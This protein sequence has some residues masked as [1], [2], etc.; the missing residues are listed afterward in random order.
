MGGNS[1]PR[2]TARY[3]WCFHHKRGPYN[4]LSHFSWV[5]KRDTSRHVVRYV[6]S[7]WH[8]TYQVRVQLA[9]RTILYWPV[10][11]HSVETWL[12]QE[13][14]RISFACLFQHLEPFQRILP[15]TKHGYTSNHLWTVST[16]TIIGDSVQ[17]RFPL[18]EFHVEPNLAVPF[19]PVSYIWVDSLSWWHDFIN[20]SHLTRAYSDKI[21]ETYMI[22]YI[23]NHR[24]SKFERDKRDF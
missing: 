1:L 19:G 17:N 21:L 20:V 3:L 22:I 11:D 18:Q 5:R 6:A 23:I 13:M 14:K 16:R 12:K 10:P 8:H 7:V 4:W 24:H 2:D 15:K 9:N